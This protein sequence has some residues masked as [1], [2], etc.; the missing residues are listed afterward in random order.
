MKRSRRNAHERGEALVETLLLLAGALL[1]LLALIALTARLELAR[2]SVDQTAR[3]AAR[4]ASQATSGPAASAAAQSA[5]RRAQQHS[6]NQ[7]TLSLRGQL[8][9]GGAF[10]ATVTSSVDLAA[11]GPLVGALARVR[12]SAQ[13]TIPVDRYRSLP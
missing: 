8:V 6:T 3:D 10:T 4:A 1:P 11:L 7:L 13:A 12:I 9:R 5:L 2:L